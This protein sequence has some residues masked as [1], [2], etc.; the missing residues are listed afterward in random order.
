MDV[1]P[2]VAKA[3]ILY[4]EERAKERD[5]KKK[6]LNLETLDP[7]SER[8]DLNQLRVLASRYLLRSGDL[9]TE[10][11]T[12]LFERVAIMA[13]I[14]ELIWD[15][16]DRSSRIIPPLI[17]IDDSD[18]HVESSSSTSTTERRSRGCIGL[19][20]RPGSR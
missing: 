10:T 1:Y 5:E 18:I 17:D 20:C 12:E 19:R 15:T 6:L 7:V 13:Y 14:P 11:P 9:I 2:D 3:Y 8:Y 4:R 16:G